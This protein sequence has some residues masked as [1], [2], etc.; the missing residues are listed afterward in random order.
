MDVYIYFFTPPSTLLGAPWL[1]IEAGTLFFPPHLAT[2][3]PFD[4][5][6]QGVDPERLILFSK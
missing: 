5:R 1:L 4:M 6:E 3:A 2:F